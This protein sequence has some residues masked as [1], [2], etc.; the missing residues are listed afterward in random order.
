MSSFSPSSGLTVPRN[1]SAKG[2]G[3]FFII[4]IIDRMV[5]LNLRTQTCDIP[6]QDIITEDNVTVRVNAVAY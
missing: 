1:T 2:P 6:P 3:P 4:P 5:R